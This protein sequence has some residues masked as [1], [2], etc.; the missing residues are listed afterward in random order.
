[1]IPMPTMILGPR[2]PFLLGPR[3]FQFSAV[4]PHVPMRNILAPIRRNHI[5]AELPWCFTKG[6]DLFPLQI[7]KIIVVGDLCGEEPLDQSVCRDT[8]DNN[9]K[10][11]FG[12]WDTAGQ[13]CFK[14]IASTYYHGA[15]PIIIVFDLNDMASLGHTRQSLLDALKENNPS[16]IILRKDLSSPVKYSFIKRDTLKVTKEMEAEYWTVSSLTDENAWEFFFLVAELTFKGS[17]V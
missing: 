15:Q 2:P 14:C 8:I 1:G 4:K 17:V 10:V 6:A 9:Y 5:I 11:T 12:L 3:K 7:S 13:E 16:N